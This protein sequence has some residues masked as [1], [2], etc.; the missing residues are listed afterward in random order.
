MSAALTAEQHA[1][2]MTKYVADGVTRAKALGNRGPLTL[3]A[4]G[5]LTPDIIDAYERTGFY[6]FE[7]C[8]KQAKL[9]CFSGHGLAGSRTIDNGAKVD[10]QGRPAFGQSCPPVYS[11]IQPL[12]DL[13]WHPRWWSH[14]IK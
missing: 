9:T 8:V 3:G 13:G 12:A 14:P 1:E 10:H 6:I 11:M 7:G 5:K 2:T 4:K